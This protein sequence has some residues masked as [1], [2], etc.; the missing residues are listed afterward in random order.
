MFMFMDL[1][2]PHKFYIMVLRMYMIV[3][4]LSLFRKA[5]SAM[6]I[7]VAVYSLSLGNFKNSS[8][9]SY[10]NRNISSLETM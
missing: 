8:A 4:Y 6:K 5:A 2:T 7:S 9:L 1:Y 3:P 10:M